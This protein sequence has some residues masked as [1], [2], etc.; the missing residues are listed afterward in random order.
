M[1]KAAGQFDF[2]S[3]L[4]V[5]EHVP[6]DRVLPL[7]DLIHGALRPGGRFLCQVPNLAAFYSPLFYMDFSHET[8]FTATSL[9]QVLELTGFGNTRIIPMGPVPHGLIS[10]TRFVLWRAIAAGL[11]FIQVI[12]GGP[13]DPLSSIYSAAILGV[14]EKC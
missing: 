7:L 1:H 6:K 11:R 3:A 2:I 5:L 4:D 10:A 12:E 8:P 9:K 13:R 14:G